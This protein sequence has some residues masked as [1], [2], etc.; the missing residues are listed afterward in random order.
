MIVVQ[1][2]AAAAHGDEPRIPD[3]GKDH[4]PDRTTRDH[5]GVPGRTGRAYNSGM[6]RAPAPVR[7]ALSTILAACAVALLAVLVLA[8]TVLAD[9]RDPRCGDWERHGVP[10]G[11]NMAL[12][13]PGGGGVGLGDIQ[14]G[15]E[16]LV[17]YI[18]G[19]LVVAVVL[20]GFGLV[21]MRLL[22][23]PKRPLRPDDLW[24]CAA[25]GTANLPTRTSCHACQSPA[26]GR[27]CIRGDAA[28]VRLD[29]HDR[30]ARVPGS[31]VPA[32]PCAAGR[33]AR[34]A[35]RAPGCGRRR[36]GAR[37]GAHAA[38][39]AVARPTTPP[40]PSSTR[41][42]HPWS[43][44]RRPGRCARSRGLPVD[45]GRPRRARRSDWTRRRATA[46]SRRGVVA[47]AGYLGLDAIPDDCRDT[48]LGIVRA[49][50]R[51]DR[52]CWRRL[53]GTAPRTPD[54]MTP[55]FHLHPQFPVGVRDALAVRV[56]GDLRRRRGRRRSC[57]LG[58]FGDDRAEP[59][60]PGGRH[61]GQELVV[62]RVAW[63]DGIE[64]PTDRDGRSRS[65]MTPA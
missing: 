63:V 50:L 65:P 16:P 2:A 37:A 34:R 54:R 58:R 39:A 36:G 44:R 14:L 57:I 22:A 18:V 31:P 3:L 52:P 7:G 26:R 19:L 13:C 41:R 45:D 24:P 60:V 46:A 9:D 1:E 20:G 25:C 43:A 49:V 5:R 23:T 15:D 64:Y 11:T 42:S 62:E 28:R 56:R 35:G 17:P 27:R 6:R 10:P 40:S 51:A 29:E 4:G 8:P 30:P 12:M 47:V 33:R 53:P 21:A 61:C 59:C 32:S 48:R 38:T 55:G